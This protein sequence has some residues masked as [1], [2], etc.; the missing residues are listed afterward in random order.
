MLNKLT[1]NEIVEKLKKL[2]FKTEFLKA[3]DSCNGRDHNVAKV[4]A[5]LQVKD[6]L[7]INKTF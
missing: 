7:K 6:P 4:E 1:N 3:C 2:Y 5:A